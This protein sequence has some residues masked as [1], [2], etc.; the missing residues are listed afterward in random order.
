MDKIWFNVWVCTVRT[1]RS[2]GDDKSDL[3]FLFLKQRRWSCDSSCCNIW[4]NCR[5]D[6]LG[7]LDYDLARVF[8]NEQVS[9]KYMYLFLFILQ[10]ILLTKTILKQNVDFDLLSRPCMEIFALCG[11]VLNLYEL[12]VLSLMNRN[13]PP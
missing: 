13:I 2:R 8:V 6:L 10:A 5:G 9:G 11:L 3:T 4:Q 12:V 1:Y 7:A